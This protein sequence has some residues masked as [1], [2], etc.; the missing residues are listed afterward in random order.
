MIRN[1]TPD[2]FAIIADMGEHFHTE[3][4]LSALAAYD[5]Q[6][7]MDLLAMLTDAPNGLLLVAE[8]DG[9]IVGMAGG[10][11]FPVYFNAA[12]KIGQEFFW[13]VQPEHRRGVGGLLKRA[14]EDAAREAG[15]AHWFMIALETVRPAAVGA[16]YRRDGYR[17]WEHSYMK[18]L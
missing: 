11:V 4:G 5:R 17:A 2:D 14:L 6:S 10:M 13:W 15:A 1:A 7:I 9:A 12:V 8:A 18:E 16:L 3:G